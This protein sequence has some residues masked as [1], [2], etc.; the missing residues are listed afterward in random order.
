VFLDY[1]NGVTSTPVD[2]KNTTSHDA[3]NLQV[4]DPERKLTAGKTSIWFRLDGTG[5]QNF[6]LD[7]L[8]FDRIADG[9]T[10]TF[11]APVGGDVPATLGLSLAGDLRFGQFRPGVANDYTAA[12]TATVTS[13]AQDAALSVTG[14]KLTNG[15]HTLVAPLRIKAGAADLAPLDGPLSLQSWTGPVSNEATPIEVHQA[16]G[17][18]DPLATGTYATTLVFTLST[19]R[20]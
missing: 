12:T 9:P 7:Y 17:A 18:N 2:V 10:M 3:F 15:T 13:S 5:T 8:R 14:G 19:T 1:G 20:P 11:P 16:I 6:N 4:L